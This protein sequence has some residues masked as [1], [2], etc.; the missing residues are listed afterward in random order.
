MPQLHCTA[1]IFIKSVVSSKVDSAILDKI[2]AFSV[3]PLKQRLS[4]EN[5]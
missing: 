2:K 5:H 3:A 1:S 4:L